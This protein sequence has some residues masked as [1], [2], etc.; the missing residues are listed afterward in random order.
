ML[1]LQSRVMTW[2]GIR[3]NWRPHLEPC[4][5]ESSDPRIPVSLRGSAHSCKLWNSQNMG[6]FWPPRIGISSLQTNYGPSLILQNYLLRNL[7]EFCEISK[8]TL[9]TE[10][11]W[12]TASVNKYSWIFIRKFREHE[13]VFECFSVQVKHCFKD[14]LLYNN[15]FQETAN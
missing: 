7:H 10:H 6:E 14:S 2:A 13:E 3:S 15:C 1:T 5:S 9:F 11:F 4:H 12:A 8:N